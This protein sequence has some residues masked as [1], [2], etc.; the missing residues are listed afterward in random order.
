MD[1][2]AEHL[3]L[4]AANIQC[5]ANKGQSWLISYNKEIDRETERGRGSGSIKKKP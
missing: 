2:S 1:C 4:W 5:H 3:A